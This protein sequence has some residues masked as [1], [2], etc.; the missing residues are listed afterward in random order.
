MS[1]DCTFAQIGT[2]GVMATV[3]SSRGRRLLIGA[4]LLGGLLAAVLMA[5][6]FGDDSAEPVRVGAGGSQTVSGRDDQ[7]ESD[8]DRCAQMRYDAGVEAQQSARQRE[9][10]VERSTAQASTVGVVQFA[11]R[12]AIGLDDLRALTNGMEILELSITVPGFVSGTNLNSTNEIVAD[13]PIGLQIDGWRE[14]LVASLARERGSLPVNDVQ[15]VDKVSARIESGDLPFIAATVRASYGA[16]GQALLG[17]PNVYSV[18]VEQV[19][20]PWPPDDATNAAVA[21]AC[22]PGSK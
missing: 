19:D 2:N 9:L 1:D 11:L 3:R 4:V 22:N 5:G 14:R 7:I 12:E 21:A 10:L 18:A 8:S 13:R 20:A 15:A 6:E 17:S 16:I